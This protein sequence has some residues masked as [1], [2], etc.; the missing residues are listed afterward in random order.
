MCLSSPRPTRKPVITSSMMKT[1]PCSSQTSRIALQETINRFHQ[2]HV[3]C[4]WLYNYTG[5]F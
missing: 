2:I 3:S 5:N 1:E 4:Y